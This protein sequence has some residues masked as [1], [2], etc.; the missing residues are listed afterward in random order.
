[1]AGLLLL[2]VA[3]LVTHLLILLAGTGSIESVSITWSTQTYLVDIG[4]F[5]DGSKLEISWF[6]SGY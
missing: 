3:K 4:A 5:E 2:G 1:M 6:E